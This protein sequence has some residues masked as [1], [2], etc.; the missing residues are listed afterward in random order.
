MAGDRAPVR[1]LTRPLNPLNWRNFQ[2]W[3][4][5]RKPVRVADRFAA[6]AALIAVASAVLIAEP[7]RAG[8]DQ[9]SRTPAGLSGLFSRAF[10]SGPAAPDIA[11]SVYGGYTIARDSDVILKQ[12]N[13][14]DMVL[15]GVS[16]N[17][18]PHNMPPYHGFRGTWWFAPGRSLGAMADL[19][20][21]KVVAD[22]DRPVRQ[23]GMR[24]G[25][26][27]PEKEPVSATF[28]R[29]E[30]TDGLNL[31]TGSVVYRM[32]FFGRVR[33]YI[34]FG[35]GLS[36]PHAEVQRRNASQRTFSFQW[37]GYAFHAFAGIE[38]RIAKSGSLFTEY[39]LSYATNTVRLIDGGTL[40]TDLWIDHF[41]AGGSGYVRPAP[42]PI[43]D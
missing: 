23:S 35:A 18:E 32:P 12:P 22:Q 8:P 9:A 42:G 21:I 10:W 28:R 14:T 7:D 38:Y 19:V 30:F 29:L 39:R 6:G 41:S 20:Y 43:G 33:P 24:D 16:W 15:K 2:I 11:G 31:L 40:E 17:S 26:Q 5:D 36:V 34:G 13:G 27:V 25:V 4:E 3:R 37:T 1:P